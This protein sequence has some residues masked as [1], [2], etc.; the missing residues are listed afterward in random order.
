[1]GYNSF[2]GY[3]ERALVGNIERYSTCLHSCSAPVSALVIVLSD[4]PSERIRKL[5]TCTTVDERL[6]EALVT[7]NAL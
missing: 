7:K 2:V 6:A 3:T 4:N 1:M 5:E